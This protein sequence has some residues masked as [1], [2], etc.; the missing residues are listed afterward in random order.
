VQVLGNAKG[1]V[2][3][4]LS[5]IYFRNPVNFYSVFGYGVTMTGVVMYSQAKKAAKRTAMLQ[6][7][8]G[9]EPGGDGLLGGE[10]QQQQQQQQQQA[11]AAAAAAKGGGTNGNAAETTALLRAAEKLGSGK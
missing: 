8:A 1:V 3:V 11:A 5:L 6:K 2:A 4:V 10:Q 7:M 9:A